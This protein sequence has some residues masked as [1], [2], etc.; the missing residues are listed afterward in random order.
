[1]HTHKEANKVADYIVG[2]S[3]APVGLHW[4]PTSDC[5][6]EYFLQYDCMSI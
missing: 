1:M 3:H 6:L 2:I 5:N 4:I